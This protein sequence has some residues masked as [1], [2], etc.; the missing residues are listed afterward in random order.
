VLVALC[1]GQPDD[2][3][4][5]FEVALAGGL[6]VVDATTPD[7]PSVEARRVVPP[8]AVPDVAADGDL[9][10]ALDGRL[11]ESVAPADVAGRAW[12][13]DVSE[14]GGP[15]VLG[16][17]DLPAPAAGDRVAVDG[18]RG[19]AA[20]RDGI[21]GLELSV[22]GVPRAVAVIDE[23]PLALALESDV[24]YALSAGRLAL[25]DVTEP[26]APRPAGD[27]A[28]LRAGRDLAV[29]GGQTVLVGDDRLIVVSRSDGQPTVMD[30]LDG[31]DL[32]TMRVATDGV[33]AFV[34]GTTAG[35]GELREVDVTPGAM[36]IRSALELATDD[37]A[38]PTGVATDGRYVVVGDLAGA[39]HLVDVSAPGRPRQVDRVP[40]PDFI[41]AA[42]PD[43]ARIGTTVALAGDTVVVGY[44]PG[45]LVTLRIVRPPGE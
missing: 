21:V 8:L 41:D 18:A 5:G 16:S 29:A 34:A 24:L 43:Y 23:R 45:G 20:T 6:L 1:D 36:A 7:A 32:T 44:V 40:L 31:L 39:V 22:P 25:Y 26:G 11:G 9:A 30:E 38:M 17:V 13:I 35:R 19:W 27:L 2:F 33:R 42:V 28:L 12:V 37:P 4:A 14:P 3:L 10:L 15:A